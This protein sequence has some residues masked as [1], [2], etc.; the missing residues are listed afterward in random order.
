MGVGD[1]VVQPHPL[2][3]CQATAGFS[4]HATGCRKLFLWA[5]YPSV[6]SGL[7]VAPSPHLCLLALAFCLGSSSPFL[8]SIPVIDRLDYGRRAR[9]WVRKWGGSPRDSGSQMLSVLG[10]RA[11]YE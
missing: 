5:M 2:H 1:P 6:G 7:G 11:V 3:L 8:P 10:R 9:G 4:L